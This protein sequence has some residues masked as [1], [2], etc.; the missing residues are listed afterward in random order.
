MDEVWGIVDE[1]GTDV[2]CAWVGVIVLVK[3]ETGSNSGMLWD[4]AIYGSSR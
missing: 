1:N 2:F 3:K 4:D